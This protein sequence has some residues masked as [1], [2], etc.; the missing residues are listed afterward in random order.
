[1]QFPVSF[2]WPLHIR[3]SS[4]FEPIKLEVED[5]FR[6]WLGVTLGG[7][8]VNNQAEYKRLIEA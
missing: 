5:T 3:G 8:L 7:R 4:E 6:L 2:Q 1:M